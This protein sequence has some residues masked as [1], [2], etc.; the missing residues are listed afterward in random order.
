[1][2]APIA[3]SFRALEIFAAYELQ[4]A[5]VLEL[6]QVMMSHELEKS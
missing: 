4:R 6:D 1:M 2:T 3:S 5:Y